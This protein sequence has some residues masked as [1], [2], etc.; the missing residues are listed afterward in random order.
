MSYLKNITENDFKK[1]IWFISDV[2][3]YI[4]KKESGEIFAGG[5]VYLLQESNKNTEE[6]VENLPFLWLDFNASIDC[7]LENETII[8]ISPVED[9]EYAANLISFCK[10]DHHKANELLKSAF[11][12]VNWQKK[13]FNTIHEYL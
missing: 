7:K 2:Q 6:D 9:N 1:I 4:T 5:S 8:N 11:T 12:S 10:E 13:V 3:I